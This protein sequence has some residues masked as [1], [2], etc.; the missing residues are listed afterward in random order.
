[1]IQSCG[2]P[3]P[4]TIGGYSKVIGSAEPMTGFSATVEVLYC[5]AVNIT[6]ATY[7]IYCLRTNRAYLCTIFDRDRPVMVRLQEI[8]CEGFSFLDLQLSR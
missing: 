1:M 7:K 2:I 5:Q 3:V 4:L 6:M 8:R